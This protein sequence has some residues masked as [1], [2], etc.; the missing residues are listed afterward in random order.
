MWYDKYKE[1]Q[2]LIHQGEG[3]NKFWIARLDEPNNTVH[4]RWGRIGTK[5]QSKSKQFAHLFQATSFIHKRVHEQHRKGYKT[6]DAQKLDE[7][8][9]QAVIVGTQ[10]K[11]HAMTWV[12][13]GEENGYFTFCPASEARLSDPNCN[14]GLAVCIETRKP[15]LDSL[16]TEFY[17]LFTG[18]SV[19]AATG[20]PHHIKNKW[21]QGVVEQNRITPNSKLHKLVKK[22]EEAVGQSMS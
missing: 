4:W 21:T 10:N 6:I 9:I 22:V 18:D 8:T 11:C 2:T 14:P 15:M 20:K 13:M 16:N 3:H 12:E 1:E 5:G 7:L 17:M 19:Y